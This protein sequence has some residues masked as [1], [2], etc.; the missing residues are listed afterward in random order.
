VAQT[1]KHI[2]V[3]AFGSFLSTLSL[4]TSCI[5]LHCSYHIHA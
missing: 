5:A 4:F 1:S 3:F 2:L